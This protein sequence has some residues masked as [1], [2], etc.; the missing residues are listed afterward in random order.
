L[1]A[2]AL[3][4][5]FKHFILELQL[6]PEFGYIFNFMAGCGIWIYFQFMAGCG[7]T[8]PRFV[9]RLNDFLKK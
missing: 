4:D 5:F 2:K 6:F 3:T 9:K 1:E 7:P 8:K